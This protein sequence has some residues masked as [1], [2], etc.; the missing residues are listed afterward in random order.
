VSGGLL[1]VLLIVVSWLWSNGQRYLRQG[2]DLLN[3]GRY[4]D[5]RAR[6]QQAKR[7]NPLSRRAGCGL[8]AVELDAIR[9]DRV[10]FEQR[11][12]E[13]NREYPACAWL[14]ML[15]GD[16]KYGGGD[17]E[18]ALAEYQ[19]AVKHE[20]QLAE[21]YFNMG[22]I[23]DLDENPDSALEQ[24]QTAT[25]LSPSTAR[26]R[27]NLADL[28]FRREEYGKAIVEYGQIDRLP[29]AAIEVAKIYRLQGK[30]EDARGREEDAIRWLKDGD[31]KNPW[32]FE[33]SPIGKVRI[34]EEKQCYADLELAV[35]RFLQ[36]HESDAANAISA[37]L[38]RC[39]S[40]QE[41]L[42]SILRWELRRLGNEAP[43]FTERCEKIVQR[44][45]GSGS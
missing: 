19:V 17:R 22:I 6:F 44:F 40:R 29:L 27:S 14:E 21:A 26:Y 1:V 9:S 5:A 2:A 31:E 36:G 33:I 16:R 43:A 12:G 35:T 3:V 15:E 8:E 34:I 10:R 18:G 42:K 25:R 38:D 32:V 45:L 23:F 4:S 13:A 24:Y 11:L 28:Y 39:R 7:L 20:P 37:A 41:E 30:L